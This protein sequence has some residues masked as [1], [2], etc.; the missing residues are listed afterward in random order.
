MLRISVITCTHN[1]R[2]DYL[3]ATVEALR[4]QSLPLHQWEYLLIDNASAPHQRP[5]V[6][7]SW[8]PHGKVIREETLGLTPARLRG[9]G[10]AQGALLVFVDDDN[11]LDA[12]YLEQ[13]IKTGEDKP[14][15]GSWSGQ[16]LPSFD[17]AP[18]E[19]TRRYWGNLAIRKFD[20]DVWSNLPRLADT[21]PCGAGLC[22]RREVA[23]HY[24]HL[25]EARRERIQLDRKGDSLRSG[26]DNELA[27]CA[28]DLGLGVGLITSLK[29]THL[30][31]AQRLTVDYQARLAEG[32]QF[33][34]ILLDADRNIDYPKR[35]LLGKVVDHLRLLRLRG[36]H[37]QISKA[38]QRGRTN[39]WIELGRRLT[40]ENSSHR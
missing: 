4:H 19:W 16:C 27:G 23:H 5:A 13:A 29:L 30:I 14:F 22:V 8:H 24:A 12:N 26:G 32:I 3:E 28:C 35:T 40:R 25:Q 33:S 31:P 18:P 39:A 20:R 17:E 6:D 21:M 11:V 37:R 36:P 15:L 9:I 1:P 7:L 38:V 2:T 34:S 10:E